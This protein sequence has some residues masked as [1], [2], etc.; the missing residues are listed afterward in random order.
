MAMAVPQKDGSG[1]PCPNRGRKRQNAEWCP[2]CYVN[3][4]GRERFKGHL[5]YHAERTGYIPWEKY[6]MKKPD[7]ATTR[8]GTTQGACP[9]PLLAKYT[10]ICEYLTTMSWEDGT[11]RA[12][13]KLSL[14][15]EDGCILI[16]LNDVDLKQSAYTSSTSL[17]EGLKL[18]EGALKGSQITWRPWKSG[19]GRK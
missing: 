8:G 17:Q 10:S 15:V 3:F 16:A 14:S 12:P 5:G 13:S 11:P 1:G 4:R 6:I 2:W 9:C 7:M 18:L 19:K